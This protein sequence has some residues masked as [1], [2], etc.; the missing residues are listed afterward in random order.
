M[1]DA[2]AFI[3][4]IKAH[5]D[6]FYIIHYSSE[7]LFDQTIEGITPRINSVVVCQYST[8]QLQSFAIHIAADVLGRHLAPGI[9]RSQIFANL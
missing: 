2:S 9:G 8:G 1:P 4:E 6:R 5:P 3:A 7:H